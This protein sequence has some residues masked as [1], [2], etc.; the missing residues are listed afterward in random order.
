[1]KIGKNITYGGIIAAVYA[2]LCYALW[3]VAFGPVQFRIAEG[4]TLLPLIL[5]GSVMGLFIGCILANL[6]SPYFILDVIFGSLATLIGAVGTFLIGKRIKNERLKLALAP[7]PPIISNTIIIGGV[8][9]YMA[10]A[11][12]EAVT[13]AVIAGQIALSEIAACY[14]V[15]IVVLY[16][17]RRA[18]TGWQSRAETK[19]G[20][21][22]L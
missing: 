15:G 12:G 16:A 17:V 13:F 19:K 22:T 18:M 4:L 8:L 2:A 10:A 21:D 7:L 3:P 6:S 9:T 20:G 5:P 11:E 14:G 1:M